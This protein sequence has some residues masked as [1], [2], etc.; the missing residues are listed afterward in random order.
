MCKAI[1]IDAGDGWGRGY[2]AAA[3][4]WR[5][6]RAGS[7]SSQIRAISEWGNG[8]GGGA[9]AIKTTQAILQLK[10]VAV[11]GLAAKV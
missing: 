7:R 3:L 2:S 6:F 8:A 9:K 1:G 4:A 10:R 11:F 5:I